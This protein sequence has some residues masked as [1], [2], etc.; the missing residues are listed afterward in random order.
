MVR[1][2]L[3]GC[4]TSSQSTECRETPFKLFPSAVVRFLKPTKDLETFDDL[5]IAAL[6]LLLSNSLKMDFEKIPCT[7]ANARKHIQRAYYQQQLWIQAPLEDGLEMN[8]E[9][10]GFTKRFNSSWYCYLQA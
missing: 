10:Y 7:S 1:R 3:A 2:N 4:I 9:S 5:R 8:T 6:E